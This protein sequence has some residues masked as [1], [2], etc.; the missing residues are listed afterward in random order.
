MNPRFEEYETA[1]EPK[2]TFKV[3]D[4]VKYMTLFLEVIEPSGKNRTT[5]RTPSGT[6]IY[7]PTSYLTKLDPSEVV[8]HIGC[9]RG[10]VTHAISDDCFLLAKVNDPHH[11][12]CCIDMSMLDKETRELVESLLKAQE[13][14]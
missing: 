3:G 2:P 4:W 14:Q 11:R 6:I 8:I 13:E 12:A 7:P 1:K 9:L 10:T 5:C